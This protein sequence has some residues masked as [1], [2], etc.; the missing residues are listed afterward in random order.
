MIPPAPLQPNPPQKIYVWDWATRIFHWSLVTLVLFA[1]LTGWVGPE[2]MLG[3]HATAGYIIAALL[4]WR[5]VWGF[6]GPETSRFGQFVRPW[7][8]VWHHILSVLRGRPAWH[9]GH[10]PAGGWMIVALLVTLWLI[11][12]TGLIALGGEEKRGV[13]AGMFSYSVGHMAKEVHEG[14][15]SF[16]FVLVPVHVGGVLVESLLSRENLVRSMI[17]GYK[18]LPAQHPMPVLAGSRPLWA[19]GWMALLVWAVTSWSSGADQ[20]PP[21]QWRPLSMPD[22]YK[23]AC[24]EC[25]WSFHP[26]LLPNSSWQFMLSNLND[27]FG[28]DAT[29]D[30]QSLQQ[31]GEF[32]N[33]NASHTWDTEAANRFR[34]VSATDPSRI[35]AT[36]FWRK[37]HRAFSDETFS[38]KA[39]ASKINCPACHRDADNGRFDDHAIELPKEIR[40]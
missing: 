36:S 8:E 19:F 31:V 6:Y 40:L 3:L 26:S 15:V 14:L 22:S 29:L 9:V 37:K 21:S 1:A 12:I 2:W 5:L 11:L 13:L 4:A 39:V 33:A 25:H 16:L 35:T 17:T 7:Q 30:G 28:D 24:G 34:K 38:N 10:N 18:S 32:L 20:L 23:S 27:H